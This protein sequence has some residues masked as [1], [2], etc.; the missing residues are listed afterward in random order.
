MG[1]SLL[2]PSC[3]IYPIPKY[4]DLPLTLS[5]FYHLYNSFWYRLLV[6]IIQLMHVL[7]KWSNHFIKLS[8]NYKKA[9]YK[10]K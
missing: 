10:L 4:F 3:S 2:K 5:Y 7:L 6:T 1:N 9:F 8:S